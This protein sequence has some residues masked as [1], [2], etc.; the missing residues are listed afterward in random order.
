MEEELMDRLIAEARAQGYR[1]WTASTGARVFAIGDT[2][3]I[4]RYVPGTV[5]EW[6]RLLRDLTQAGL[7]WPPRNRGR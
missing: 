5:E 7:L 6:R 4:C 1:V 3:V 2:I